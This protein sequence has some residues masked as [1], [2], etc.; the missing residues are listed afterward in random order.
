MSFTQILDTISA[1]IIILDRDLKV[2][3][4]NNWLERYSSIKA[5]E[6]QGKS[7]FK[8]FPNLD[9]PW[10]LRNCK[11]VF[12]FGNFSF[13]SQKI[14]NYCFPFKNVTTLDTSFEYM[15]Q[16]CTMGPIRDEASQVQ[17]IYILVQDVTDIADYEK[18]L[19][20]IN[21]R[22]GLTGLYNRM[23]LN[24]QLDDEVN[25]LKRYG[26]KFSLIMLD[27]DHF[28]AINDNYGHLC[29]DQVLRNISGLLGKHKRAV[30]VIARYGGEEFCCLL[31]ETSLEEAEIV[32]ERI[33]TTVE[34]AVFLYEDS[35]IN[36]TVSLGL[37][38]AKD[39]SLS[40]E[41]ILKKADDALYQAKKGGRN[42]VVKMVF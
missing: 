31:P 23:Y 5:E 6:I 26:R 42:Q 10:F 39:P 34:K 11:S 9:V 30:D 33:R 14:H 12:A 24:I 36:V 20:E 37:T 28:K 7:I 16:N 41:D 13:F 2:L 40:L 8:Y 35:N 19:T 15:Q 27:I 1:G 32:A 25:R 18:K 21:N 29:G 4:W 17:Y 3:K 22:D 38:E